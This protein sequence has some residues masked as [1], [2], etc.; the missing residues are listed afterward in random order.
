MVFRR[1][2]ALFSVGR[3][4]LCFADS[5]GAARR[6]RNR[7]GA[8]AAA[9]G[10]ATTSTPTPGTPPTIADKR[11][12]NAEQLRVAQRRLEKIRPTR[13]RPSKSRG[14]KTAE[15]LFAQQEAVDQQ[16]KDL[17]APRASS[18]SSSIRSLAD[19]ANRDD[20]FVHRVRPAGE[21]AGGGEV[22]DRTGASPE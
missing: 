9:R 6:S 1:R 17:E 15:N 14:Y 10:R 4:G 8:A 22:A 12:E 2:A 21:R 20:D 13:R 18:R 3:A 19:G 11:A 16:I 5:S 7:L